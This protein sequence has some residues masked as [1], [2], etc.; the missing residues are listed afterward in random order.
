MLAVQHIFPPKRLKLQRDAMWKEQGKSERSEAVALGVPRGFYTDCVCVCV[1]P[2]KR[3]FHFCP[4]FINETLRYA[5]TRI[6]GNRKSICKCRPS[7]H[8][9]EEFDH[10]N[11]CNSCPALRKQAEKSHIF[12]VWKPCTNQRKTIVTSQPQ[13]ATKSTIQPQAAHP[14]LIEDLRLGVTHKNW[15]IH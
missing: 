2:C 13:A 3:C 1:C 9:E 8:L 4:R 6:L 11:K 12:S 5:E 7:R 10:S 15:T 14:H